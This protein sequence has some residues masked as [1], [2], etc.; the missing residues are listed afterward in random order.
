MHAAGQGTEGQ[1]RTL[2]GTVRDLVTER[3]MDRSGEGKPARPLDLC[4]FSLEKR[5]EQKGPLQESPD[6][7]LSGE[8]GKP[9]L[10]RLPA[11]AAGVGLREKVLFLKTA[12][13]QQRLQVLENNRVK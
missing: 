8:R 11:M 1:H 13:K 4:N 12:D 5:R 7:Y 9:E 3:E 2:R 6:D 10:Q